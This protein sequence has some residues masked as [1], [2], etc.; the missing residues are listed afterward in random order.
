MQYIVSLCVWLDMKL[1]ADKK[2]RHDAVIR[3]LRLRSI[4]QQQAVLFYNAGMM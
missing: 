3:F 4:W 1:P 2:P